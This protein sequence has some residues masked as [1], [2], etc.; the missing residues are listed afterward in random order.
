MNRYAL[1]FDLGPATSAVLADAAGIPE[2][3]ARAWLE[4]QAAEGVLDIVTPGGPTEREYL[5]PAVHVPRLVH[6]FLD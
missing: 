6:G 3:E 4:Q 2:P 5:L 1:M